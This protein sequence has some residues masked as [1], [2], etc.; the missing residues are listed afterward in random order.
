[1]SGRLVLVAD[2]ADDVALGLGQHLEVDREEV[3]HHLIGGDLLDRLLELHSLDV[4]LAQKL[5]K[6]R[7]IVAVGSDDLDRLLIELWPRVF[8]E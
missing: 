1:M 8:G 5:E 2:N 7:V 4:T 6:V 3:T